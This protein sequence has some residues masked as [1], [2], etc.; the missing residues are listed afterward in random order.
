MIR[1]AYLGFNRRYVNRTLECQLRAIGAVVE[2]RRYGPGYSSKDEL[3]TGP[4]EWMSRHGPFDLILFDSYVFEFPVIAARPKAFV[5]DWLRFPES[6]F[7]EAGPALHSFARDYDGQKILIA[8]WDTYAITDETVGR[9][10]SENCLVI[11][12]SMAEMSLAEK[13]ALPGA[14]GAG[15]GRGFLGGRGTD[16]WLEFRRQRPQAVIEFPHCIGEEEFDFTPVAGRPL[17]IA[18][19][20]TAYAERRLLYGDIPLGKRFQKLSIKVADRAYYAR[21]SSLTRAKLAEIHDRYD[22]ELASA[23]AAFV[24]G[25][26]YRVPVRKY[27]EVPAAGAAPIGQTCEGFAE[28]GFQ[29]GVNFIR[30]ETP[31]AVREALQAT[32]DDQLAKIAENARRLVWERHS[33]HARSEQFGLVANAIVQGRYRGSGWHSGRF[34]LTE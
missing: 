12:W 23:R 2:L 24:S 21:N 26:V 5:A 11:D 18:V 31:E 25:S 30:A 10:I 14:G 29:D 1:A 22:V 9:L 33:V 6:Q 7:R 17:S 27:F 3:A 32:D 28:L 20:G 19:P 34:E 4:E 8:N 15:S 13:L 16:H